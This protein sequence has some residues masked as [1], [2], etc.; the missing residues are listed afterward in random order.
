METN[1]AQIFV[2]V[3]NTGSFSRASQI[4]KIPKSTISRRISNLEVRLGVRLLERTTRELHLTDIG[5]GYFEH[6]ERIVREIREAESYIAQ[7]QGEPMGILK[8]SVAVDI[9]IHFLADI[10]TDFMLLYPSISIE[11]ELSQRLA[12]VISEEI[13]VAIRVRHL[14]DSSMLARK[15]GTIQLGL[16]AHPNYFPAGHIPSH[17]NQLDPDDCIGM[18]AGDSSWIFQDKNRKIKINPNH[19]FK[20]NNLDL[21]RNAVMK[22]LGIAVLPLKMTN[23]FTGKGLIQLLEEF[24]LE[25][26]NLYAVYPSSK[27]VSSKLNVF[28]D[29]LQKHLV[30]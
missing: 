25:S 20:V 14:Q 17:P 13:D 10:L 9:G 29:Y 22:G 23:T 1:D 21:I 5:R 26:G 2:K 18:L 15:I 4:L 7:A 16:F 27:H 19:R 24:P 11:A 6:C 28:L 8:V 12:N 30:S 3:V